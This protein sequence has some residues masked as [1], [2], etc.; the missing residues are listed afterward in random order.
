MRNP[1]GNLLQKDET[2]STEIL[3]VGLG[4]FGGALATE[5]VG[6]G[7]EVLGVDTDTRR[8]QE[9]RDV[10]THVMQADCT[11]GRVLEQLGVKDFTTSVVAIGS[12]VEAS[13]LVVSNL[14]EMGV[15][16]VWAKAVTDAHGRILR[17]VGADN[18]V[19]PEREMG[20]RT[21][22]LVTGQMVD[23]MEIDEGEFSLAETTAP[24]SM[25]GRQVAEINMRG[26]QGVTIVAVKP[27][28]GTFAHAHGDITVHE[29]D[30]LILAGTPT[31]T[32]AVCNQR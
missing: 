15:T 12:D 5:L 10:L 27:L 31:Q 30:V 9:Y 3:V 20:V 1:L 13:I 22:H 11:N 2:P 23:F 21:A 26:E 17:R 4:R 32:E 24:K 19:F 8:I 16:N 7:H 6:L 25:V 28:G 14:V 29:G 18:V